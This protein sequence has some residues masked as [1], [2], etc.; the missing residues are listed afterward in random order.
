MSAVLNVLDI[1]TFEWQDSFAPTAES[2]P[3]PLS[4]NSATNGT[5]PGG[6]IG[7]GNVGSITPSTPGQVTTIQT[8]VEIVASTLMMTSTLS[9]G[10][11][12]VLTEVVSIEVPTAAPYY[13]DITG[14]PVVVFKTTDHFPSPTSPATPDGAVFTTIRNGS[15]FVTVLMT[16]SSNSNTSSP[17]TISPGAIAG[18]VIG[19]I[20][21]IAWLVIVYLFLRRKSPSSDVRRS[22]L[23]LRWRNFVNIPQDG[24]TP[25]RNAFPN[26][27]E[28]MVE[29]QTWHAS[30]SQ[31][32]IEMPGPSARR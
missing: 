4:C 18:T 6:A 25:I 30:D 9:D 1:G 8:A 32:T 15:V 5:G 11:V 10:Q 21:L 19:G 7:F 2:I 28:E 12:T 29:T 13:Y 20:I 31:S 26:N 14:S 17:I 23:E 24:T 27:S 3:E 16:A 22:G